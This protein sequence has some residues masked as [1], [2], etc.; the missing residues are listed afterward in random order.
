MTHAPTCRACGDATVTPCLSLGQSPIANAFLRQEDLGKEELFFP[1]ELGFCERCLMAQLVHTVDR[2]KLF[3]KSYAYYSSISKAMTEHF[4]CFA[5]D[6]TKEFL[7]GDQ[8]LVVE[9]GSNDGILLQAFDQARV[10]VLGVEPSA[11]VAAVA[12]EKGLET[13]VAFFNESLAEDIRREKG[14]ASAVLGANVICHIPDLNELLRGV[15]RLL[16]DDGVFVFEDPSLAEI[17]RGN[18]Y[19]QIYDEH[20]YYFSVTSLD[21]LARRHGMHVFH[22]APQ[23][24]HG[25]SNRIFVARQSSKHTVRASVAG[26]LA[27]EEGL[28]LKTLEAY[29]AFAQRVEQSKRDLLGLLGELKTAGK[30]VVGYAASSKGNVVLNYCQIGPDTLEYIADNTPTKQ[31]LYSPGMHIPIVAPDVFHEDYPDYALLLAWN[32]AK[33][34]ARKET[35]FH[36]A[37]GRFITHIPSVRVLEQP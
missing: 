34:I 3:H 35:A 7:T 37:G 17:L 1:L 23:P 8:P 22:V 30:R 10:R 19:D 16:D 31:G 29:Q 2:D 32:H 4:R 25:G 36:E 11:N 28:G 15:D 18:A 20:V 26:A 5:E 33:E 9:L 21:R 6:L 27:A 12:R 14:P 24:T 13:I